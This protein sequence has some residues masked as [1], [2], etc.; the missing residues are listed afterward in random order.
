MWECASGCM[1]PETAADN[2]DSAARWQVSALF[3]ELPGGKERILAT[4]D[5]LETAGRLKGFACGGAGAGI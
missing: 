2:T 4:A 1:R 5:E 3:G